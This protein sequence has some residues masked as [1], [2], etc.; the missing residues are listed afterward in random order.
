[1]FLNNAVAANGGGG[2]RVVALG[3]IGVDGLREREVALF[4]RLCGVLRLGLE[5]SG[6]A[7]ALFR[8][9]GHDGDGLAVDAELDAPAGRRFLWFRDIH[10][11]LLFLKIR[12]ATGIPW[13]YGWYAS[14]ARSSALKSQEIP[15]R[16]ELFWFITSEY[17]RIAR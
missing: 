11:M 6:L 12:C 16:K 10:R 13:R 15:Q 9:I 3:D 14:Q 5:E 7:P 8:G 4:D 2:K 1:M 17:V